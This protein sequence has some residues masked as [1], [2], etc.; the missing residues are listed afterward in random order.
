MSIIVEDLETGL[1]ILYSKGADIAILNKLSP[2]I[3]QLFLLKTERALLEFSTKGLRTLCFAIRVLNRNV[4]NEW[5]ANLEKAKF[6]QITYSQ[7]PE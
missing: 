1:I 6:Y 2:N 7:S 5:A 4:Y 3:E